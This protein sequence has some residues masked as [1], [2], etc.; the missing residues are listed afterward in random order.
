MG[1]RKFLTKPKPVKE[2]ILSNVEKLEKDFLS[3]FENFKNENR[4]DRIFRIFISS[5]YED[6][7]KLR[8]EIFSRL[9]QTGHIPRGMELFDA[10]NEEDI[11]V[12]ADTI[13][14]SDIYIVVIGHRYGSISDKYQLSY[15]E[16][17]YRIAKL[18]QKPVIPFLLENKENSIKRSQLLGSGTK[19]SKREKKF[20]K[21]Y[22]AFRKL[23]I[24]RANPSGGNRLYRNFGTNLQLSP[25]IIDAVNNLINNSGEELGG[26]TTEA[27]ILGSMAN[28]PLAREAI[29]T[30]KKYEK[31]YQRCTEKPNLK[32]GLA[33]YFWDEAFAEIVEKKIFRV[34][35]E[36]G[37]TPVFVADE[38]R[39]A[40]ANSGINSLEEWDVSTN[41][42]LIHLRFAFAGS[43]NDQNIAA[44][45]VPPGRPDGEHGATFGDLSHVPKYHLRPKKSIPSVVNLAIKKVAKKISGERKEPTLILAAT[46]GLSLKR[47]AGVPLGPFVA[48]YENQLFKHAL[49]R[50]GSPIVF[51]MDEG[52]TTIEFEK[53]HRSICF[54][55][56]DWIDICRRHPLAICIGCSS[57][58]SRSTIRNNLRTLGLVYQA[59]NA[60]SEIYSGG[61]E[62]CFP[63]LVFNRSF[64]KFIALE[65]DQ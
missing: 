65:E 47:K 42:G 36:S 61:G 64:K 20:D 34:F 38:F 11:K 37:S 14:N 58:A 53:K 27:D 21:A 30:L 40:V 5:P 10:G 1:G 32:R 44:K 43:T 33:R 9:Q 46:T 15:T 41:N 39:K 6:L 45:L 13:W 29:R 55:P 16:L 8:K 28:N 51:F 25:Q 50:T 62:M 49:L 4:V 54:G 12:I 35:F 48:D 3:L 57:E 56:I 2:E 59:F 19:E 63:L 23:V 7:K 22:L 24:E 31:L 26:L 18:A 17:E 60:P 52:K